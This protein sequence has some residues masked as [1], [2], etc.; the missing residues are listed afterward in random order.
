MTNFAERTKRY[1]CS[2][3][4]TLLVLENHASPQVSLA[5]YF[6]AGELFNPVGKDLL[7]DITA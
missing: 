2:N 4:L 5:G 3:G 7:G 1:E 6:R